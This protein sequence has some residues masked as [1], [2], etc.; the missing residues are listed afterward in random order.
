MGRNMQPYV[1]IKKDSADVYNQ[2]YYNFTLA[3][4]DAFFKGKD[5]IYSVQAMKAYRGCRGT[6]PLIPKPRRQLEMSGQLHALPTLSSGQNSGNNLTSGWLD[7]TFDL[8]VLENTRIFVPAG[9]RI[10]DR[11]TRMLLTILTEF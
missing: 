1:L 5:K 8:D 4:C 11:P 7:H 6:A 10:P 9:I 3:L 2:F